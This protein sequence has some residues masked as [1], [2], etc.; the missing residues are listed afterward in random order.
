MRKDEQIE[1]Y[2]YPVIQMRLGIWNLSIAAHP[3]GSIIGKIFRSSIYT[4]ALD[5]AEVMKNYIVDC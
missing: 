5:D 1:Q 2:V 4:R 3:L